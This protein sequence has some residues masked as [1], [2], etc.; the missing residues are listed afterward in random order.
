MT[1]AVL[2]S[3]VLEAADL[4]VG[5][6]AGD[7]GGERLVLKSVSCR[8][9]PGWTAIVGPNGA[10]KSTLLRVLAGLLPPRTGEVRMDG[11]RL[12]DL[13]AR[14]RGRRIAWLA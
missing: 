13:N 7:G 12:A 9:E 2:P 8:F 1:A 11:R 4:Q 6:G 5:Y 10:G 3:P 14:E